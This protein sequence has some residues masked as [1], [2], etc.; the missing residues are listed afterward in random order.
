MP[1]KQGKD[2]YEAPFSDVLND[3]HLQD[4]QQ[5]QVEEPVPMTYYQKI[6][7]SSNR[8]V[9]LLQQFLW[10][11]SQLWLQQLWLDVFSDKFTSHGIYRYK[12]GFVS[13]SIIFLP[14]V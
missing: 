2:Q 1:I 4:M 10:K 5:H 3:T 7:L 9:S 6:L 8:S 12:E 11:L 14:A 13:L